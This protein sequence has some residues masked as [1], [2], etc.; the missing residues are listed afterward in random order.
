MVSE[1]YKYTYG[2]SLTSLPIRILNIRTTV[3]GVRPKFKFE[4]G[5]KKTTSLSEALKRVRKVFLK[6]LVQ[7]KFMTAFLY[8][9]ATD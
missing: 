3:I 4:F 6:T 9:Q 1:K 2:E 8:L 7:Y 5:E